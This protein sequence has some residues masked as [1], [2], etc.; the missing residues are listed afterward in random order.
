MHNEL[1]NYSDVVSLFKAVEVTHQ[2]MSHVGDYVMYVG[3]E[4][5]CVDNC[6]TV[7]TLI[8]LDYL[9]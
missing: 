2:R 4:E 9:I 8:K 7:N 6:N 1:L 5:V 3:E